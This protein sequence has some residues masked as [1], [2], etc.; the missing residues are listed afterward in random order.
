MAASRR[1]I[2]RFGEFELDPRSLELRCCGQPVELQE[3]PL[4]LLTTL[5]ENPGELVARDELHRVLWPEEDFLEFDN[6]LN[7]AM[8]RLRRALEDSAAA[9]RLVETV[10]RRGYRFIA[11]VEIVEVC[12]RGG[13]RRQGRWWFVAA[14]ALVA[15]LGWVASRPPAPSSSARGE[16]P[17]VRAHLLRAKHFEQRRSRD[18]L[19]KAIAEYQSVL[20]IDPQLAAPYA[21]LAVAY[22]LLGVYD[23][24][25]PLEAFP[26]ASRMADRALALAPEAPEAHLALS[27][28]EAFY[29][30]RWQAALTSADR[31]VELA[32]EASEP[33]EWRGILRSAFGQ[34]DD[35]LADL[36][37]ALDR[38]P[39]SVTLRTGRC[40]VL[41]NARRF[42][43]AVAECQAAAELD[44][45]HLDAWDNLKWVLFVQGR[46]V[47]AADAFARV[48]E[49]EGG[50]GEGARRLFAEGGWL[51][52]LE[53][54]IADKLER[55]EHGY[56]SAYD[57]A[58]DHCALGR[59]DEAMLWLERS[60]GLRET[61]LLLA[62]VD[63]RLDVLRARADFKA[64]LIG[65]GHGKRSTASA[66]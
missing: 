11:E 29:G 49:L 36:D 43:D 4:R 44:P 41:F 20:A 45:G 27:I 63:P 60:R 5:V 65:L 46:E 47:E 39:V 57:L 25:P 13:A 6:S 34:H 1:V 52:L 51:A 42:D 38:D 48:V 55:A 66:S 19:E 30:W 35:G 37:A 8:S 23:F 17:A 26:P 54:S 16:S 24:W 14:A 3:L 62:A 15:V 7:A 53:G 32:P 31:A 2:Y 18:G 64:W 21:G 61:D 12:E 28:V 58:L 40:W 59:A 9:P 10:P 33:L 22:A 56:Q 50:E